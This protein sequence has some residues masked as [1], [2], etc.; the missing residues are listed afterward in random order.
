[1]KPLIPHLVVLGLSTSIVIAASV[2]HPLQGQ[3]P[4]IA[5]VDQRYSWTF[6]PETFAPDQA[7]YDASSLSY[8]APDLPSWL[9]FDPLSRTFSGQPR[10]EDVGT[11]TVKVYA[12]EP[13]D[14][15]SVDS[16]RLVVTTTSPILSIPFSTQFVP[17]NTHISSAT[18]IPA[19]TDGQLIPGVR[20]PQKWSFSIGLEGGTITSPSSR[21]IFYSSTLVDRGPLPKWLIFDPDTM[22]FEG[23][24]PSIKDGEQSK[25]EVVLFGS[26]KEGYA[27]IED[28]FLFLID[29]SPSNELA[30]AS[31]P[32]PINVTVEAPFTFDFDYYN[33]HGILL[34]GVDIVR[35]NISEILV[36]T[37]GYSWLSYDKDTSHLSGYPPQDLLHQPPPILPLQVTAKENNLTASTNVT[38]NILPSVFT[39]KD[40]PLIFAPP[41]SRVWV[42]VNQYL[43]NNTI[44]GGVENLNVSATYM[45]REAASWLVFNENT[46]TLSGIVPED[47]GYTTSNITFHATYLEEQSTSY[48]SLLLNLSPVPTAEDSV[49]RKGGLSEHNKLVVGATLGVIGGVVL[50]CCILAG[51]RVWCSDKE[52]PGV[53]VID[54]GP[55]GDRAGTGAWKLSEETVRGLSVEN[56][57]DL[58]SYSCGYDGSQLAR[59]STAIGTSRAPSP[60]STS[61]TALKAPPLAHVTNAKTTKANF[62][63]K[64]KVLSST[65]LKSLGK[66]SQKDNHSTSGSNRALGDLSNK[67]KPQISKPI[68]M[69]LGSAHSALSMGMRT[70]TSPPSSGDGF[71]VT[72][73]GR[74]P[75]DPTGKFSAQTVSSSVPPSQSARLVQSKG[76]TAGRETPSDG[77]SNHILEGGI[78]REPW[79]TEPS[80]VWASG[81]IV[82]T[83]NMKQGSAT[84]NSLDSVVPK[85]RKDFRPLG[86]SKDGKRVVVDSTVVEPS[87]SNTSMQ[88]SRGLQ[89][90][91]AISSSSAQDGL[92]ADPSDDAIISTANRQHVVGVATPKRS[93]HSFQTVATDSS[94]N[95]PN[96]LSVTTSKQSD[97]SASGSGYE[98]DSGVDQS[99]REGEK[100]RLVNFSHERKAGNMLK[101]NGQRSVSHQAVITSGSTDAGNRV[102]GSTSKIQAA[103]PEEPET[104]LDEK[105]GLGLDYV[106]AFGMDGDNAGKTPL[107]FNSPPLPS[108]AAGP[109]G[110]DPNSTLP[111]S[112]SSASEVSGRSGRAR[113][114][115]PGT[116]SH[117]SAYG[118][119]KTTTKVESPSLGSVVSNS[120]TSVYTS[121]TQPPH[122][123]RGGDTESTSP[124]RLRTNIANQLRTSTHRILVGEGQPFNFSV[125]LSSPLEGFKSNQDL[126][127]TLENGDELPDWLR[128]D[129]REMEFWGVPPAG[130][131][132]NLGVCVWQNE[133]CVAVFVVEIVNR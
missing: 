54:H 124:S 102:G 11:I 22:T 14:S 105:L 83:P 12:Y 45:P 55:Y 51:C 63:K 110:R 59:T 130:S 53:Y 68:P 85:Q 28:H 47:V 32:I 1:M 7:T 109:S 126:S 90:L 78:D 57:K 113:S 20:V 125:P 74:V 5:V 33:F 101:G 23:I 37:S 132:A 119:S 27:G 98:T 104:D 111:S 82:K 35:G 129:Q 43:S 122:K 18:I 79:A 16:F 121:H 73:N 128:F 131:K 114:L 67:L 3:I 69:P 115:Y 88:S 70:G 39:T 81:K 65:S 64:L 96:Q 52:P 87:S 75:V 2:D 95:L 93:I 4:Q 127:A 29:S 40:I 133:R 19:G 48:S 26:E 107:F 30:V 38:L 42:D 17:T 116:T 10:M 89:R 9:A 118:G 108:S 117:R 60:F 15:E 99:G 112:E 44:R 13:D 21:T 84:E 100:P 76:N 61:T 77:S 92:A 58:D 66:R 8:N 31:S 24:T 94:P 106:R 25:F 56:E 41:A 86:T 36:D 72:S 91:S 123:I 71:P 6:N 46:H 62:F 120:P 80:Y 49:H 103:V 34:N 97:E 50:L